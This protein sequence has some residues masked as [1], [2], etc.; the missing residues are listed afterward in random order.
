MEQ[1]PKEKFNEAI[2]VV[3]EY[4]R[5]RI[6]E[7]ATEEWNNNSNI[8]EDYLNEWNLYEDIRIHHS[9]P[10]EYFVSSAILSAMEDECPGGI[11]L[12]D[13]IF[14]DEFDVLT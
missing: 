7:L 9:S 12:D 1:I 8:R 14:N 11:C 2:K 10:F 6:I 4:I 13:E 5:Q 3:R